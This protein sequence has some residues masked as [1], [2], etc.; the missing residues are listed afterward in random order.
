M[1]RENIPSPTAVS[2]TSEGEREGTLSAVNPHYHKRFFLRGGGHC[3]NSLSNSNNSTIK[4]TKQTS[5]SSMLHTQPC[6]MP[7]SQFCIHLILFDFECLYI[8]AFRKIFSLLKKKVISLQH[9]HSKSCFSD[10]C[11]MQL[12]VS[13]LQFL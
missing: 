2:W 4:K 5:N 11:S 9:I 7:M 12:N 6:S 13:T 8:F 3:N 1:V 10:K